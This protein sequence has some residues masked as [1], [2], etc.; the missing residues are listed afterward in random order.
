MFEKELF[1]CTKMDLALNNLQWLICNKTKPNRSLSVSFHFTI[2][3]TKFA[4]A[5]NL[6]FIRWALFYFAYHEEM[7][8]HIRFPELKIS[9]TFLLNN[10][11]GEV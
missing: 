10:I 7:L 11:G 4:L 6:L 3:S 9:E 1:L 5:I 2:H 8:N